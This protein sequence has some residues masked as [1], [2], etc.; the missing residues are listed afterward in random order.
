MSTEKKSGKAIYATLKEAKNF[1]VVDKG[2]SF[3]FQ[4]PKWLAEL[5]TAID[6]GDRNEITNWAERHDFVPELICEGISQ[7]IIDLRALAR[8]RKSEG[9]LGT[10]AQQ[11][12][13]NNYRPSL[14][15]K[16]E[17]STA[18]KARLENIAKARKIVKTMRSLGQPNDMI[19]PVLV[20]LLD[21]STANSLLDE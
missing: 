17:I 12:R 11:E 16:P 13:L 6:T 14:I 18:E 21:E 19:R 3:D 7:V 5:P 15:E 20:A 2:E 8:R 9:I 4:L 1:T 10:P